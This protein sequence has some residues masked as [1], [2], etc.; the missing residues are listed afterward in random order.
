MSTTTEKWTAV[1]ERLS[2]LGLKLQLH[3]DQAAT[4]GEPAVEDGLRE[5]WREV[6]DA[7]EGAFAA[8]GNAARDEAVR[9]DARAVGRSLVEALD[10]TFSSI[11][12]RLG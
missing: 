2:A 9:E 3:L 11:S 8:L 6:G 12:R 10:E 1:A 4:D 5:A 7:V